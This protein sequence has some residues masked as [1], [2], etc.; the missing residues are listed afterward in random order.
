MRHVTELP[1]LNRRWIPLDTNKDVAYSRYARTQTDVHSQRHTPAGGVVGGGSEL[2]TKSL[3]LWHFFGSIVQVSSA[4][5]LLNKWIWNDLPRVSATWAQMHAL[6]L[7][8]TPTTTHSTTPACCS[9]KRRWHK[10]THRRWGE[11]RAASFYC[12]RSHERDHCLHVCFQMQR[13][14]WPMSLLI[15]LQSWSVHDQ[16][17]MQH[18]ELKYVPSLFRSNEWDGIEAVAA[19]RTCDSNIWITAAVVTN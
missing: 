19:C 7:A 2:Q 16:L 12:P 5:R 11:S 14:W 13:K 9:R 3:T 18:Y 10:R 1:N 15:S 6:L 17:L 8:H 4:H